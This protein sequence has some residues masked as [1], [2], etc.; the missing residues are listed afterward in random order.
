MGVNSPQRMFPV[1]MLCPG[2]GV[3]V[4]AILLHTLDAVSQLW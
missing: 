3:G 2:S 4:A 1:A